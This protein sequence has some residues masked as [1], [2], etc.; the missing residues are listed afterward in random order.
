MIT[1]IDIIKPILELLACIDIGDP[2]VGIFENR[3]VAQLSLRCDDDTHILWIRT[4]A[5]PL[6]FVFGVVFP[7]VLTRILFKNKKEKRLYSKL[8][9]ST[10]GCLFSGY[11]PTRNF[12]EI[13]II[14]RKFLVLQINFKWVGRKVF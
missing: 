8:V 12:Y 9:V 10:Y 5:I 4:C 3:L 6:L 14:F 13:I 11:I 1:F 2:N 7:F